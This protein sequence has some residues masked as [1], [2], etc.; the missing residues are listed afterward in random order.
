MLE[1]IERARVVPRTLDYAGNWKFFPASRNGVDE[2]IY[3][4]LKFVK[5]V[6]GVK[7]RSS[8]HRYGSRHTRNHS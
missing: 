1:S 2:G 3:S 7:K 4:D 8:N 6:D 5:V